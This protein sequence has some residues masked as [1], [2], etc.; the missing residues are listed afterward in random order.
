MSVRIEVVMYAGFKIETPTNEQFDKYSEYNSKFK[1]SGWESKSDMTGSF[2]LVGRELGIVKPEGNKDSDD[3]DDWSL[4]LESY[5]D[6]LNAEFPELNHLEPRL[7]L[8]VLYL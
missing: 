6:E 2:L 7:H 3:Y 4:Y 1:D 8:Q 5:Y